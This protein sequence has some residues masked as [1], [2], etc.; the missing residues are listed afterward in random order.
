M[1]CCWHPPVR[2]WPR[3]IVEVPPGSPVHV[4]VDVHAQCE[5]KCTR[6]SLWCE[7]PF[8]IEHGHEPGRMPQFLPLPSPALPNCEQPIMYTSNSQPHLRTRLSKAHATQRLKCMLCTQNWHPASRSVLQLLEF[9]PAYDSTN[10]VSRLHRRVAMQVREIASINGGCSCRF[11]CCLSPS[12]VVF[13]L[14]FLRRP[15]ICIFL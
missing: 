1:L 9:T 7:T 2:Q 11:Y 4:H 3:F 14:T 15:R 5:A 12:S 8:P 13:C 10:H 6:V